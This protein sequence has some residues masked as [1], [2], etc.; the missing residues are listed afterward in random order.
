VPSIQ[1]RLGILRITRCA[2][3]NYVKREASF[4]EAIAPRRSETRRASRATCLLM[5]TRG[6]IPL[7]ATRALSSTT[8]PVRLRLTVTPIVEARGWRD[9]ARRMPRAPLTLRLSLRSAANYPT[10]CGRMSGL[11]LT[12]P[13]PSLSILIH[14]DCVFVFNGQGRGGFPPH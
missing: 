13:H 1:S 9:F 7:S 2:S 4:H 6:E 3:T 8:A 12:P 11:Q 5:S 10:A 14:V